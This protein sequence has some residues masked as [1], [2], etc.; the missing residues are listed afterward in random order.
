MPTSSFTGR[1]LLPAY[2]IVVM[3]AW[4]GRI[5]WVAL[6]LV[7]GLSSGAQA[8]Y[9]QTPSPA[10]TQDPGLAGVRADLERMREELAAMR[11]ELRALREL[12]QRQATPPQAAAP[13]RVTVTTADSPALGRRDAP[14]T[15]V[16]FSDY[17][18]PFCRQFVST[19]LPA[20]KSAYV[21]SGKARYVF[22][23]FPIDNIHPQARKAAEAA[24]CAGDQGKYWEMHDLLFQNQQALAPEQLP[25]Y[26]KR[27]GLDAAAFSACL[28]SAKHAGAVQQNYGEGAAAG[29]RGTPSFIVGRTRPDNTVEGLLI[30]GA[31]PLADFRQEIDRLL[32]EK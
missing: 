30:V 11:S 20:L 10:P 3:R 22:R 13:R 26:A 12:L 17:Q 27:L 18:C 32:N 8:A 6:A 5:G 7:I 24:H 1:I 14:V 23:D 2:N 31:R 15:I 4:Q 25:H 9:G 19:T 28:D 16:E 21:D 29:V